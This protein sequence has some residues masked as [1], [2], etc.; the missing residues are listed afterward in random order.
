MIK[1]IIVRIKIEVIS[2]VLIQYFALIPKSY[3]LHNIKQYTL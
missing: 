3:I 1:I 2:T